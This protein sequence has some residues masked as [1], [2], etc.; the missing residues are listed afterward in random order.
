MDCSDRS[1]EYVYRGRMSF[2]RHKLYYHSNDDL[3]QEGKAGHG[4][5]I[6]KAGAGATPSTALIMIGGP[7]WY[8]FVLYIS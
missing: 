3:G 8:L 7:A 1:G 6:S 4:R 2:L 5:T